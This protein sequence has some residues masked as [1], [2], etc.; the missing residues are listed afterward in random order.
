MSTSLQALK[1]KLTDVWISFMST[2]LQAQN[3][4]KNPQ[5]TTENTRKKPLAHPAGQQGD[6][7]GGVAKRVCEATWTSVPLHD[8]PRQPHIRR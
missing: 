7:Q 1:N 2:S 5:N 6:T 4:Q 8:S 3:N